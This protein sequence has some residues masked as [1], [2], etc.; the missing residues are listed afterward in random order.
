MK[1]LLRKRQAFFFRKLSEYSECPK[2]KST[3]DRVLA[4]YSHYSGQVN[5]FFLRSLCQYNIQRELFYPRYGFREKIMYAFGIVV[6]VLKSIYYRLCFEFESKQ[7]ASRKVMFTEH[8]HVFNKVLFEEISAARLVSEVKPLFSMK[9]MRY[10]LADIETVRTNQV[11]AEFLYYTYL[12]LSIYTF[13][14]L[15]YQ[16]KTIYSCMEQ[17]FTCSLVTGFLR[18]SGVVHVNLQHGIYFNKGPLVCFAAFDRFYV[19]QEELVKYF[20]SMFVVSE[21]SRFTTNYTKELRGIERDIRAKRSV[22]VFYSIYLTTSMANRL[23]LNSVLTMLGRSF[24]VFFKDHPLDPGGRELLAELAVTHPKVSF[25]RTAE[26]PKLV[27]S[28]ASVSISAL[29]AILR[30]SVESGALTI[31][32]GRDS[33]LKHMFKDRILSW[34]SDGQK[35]IRSAIESA[36]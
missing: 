10:M 8:K 11:T 18:T 23:A 34:E 21:F 35:K 17:N 30:D 27:L 29:S 31:S 26:E 5:D 33:M 3:I 16:P 4:F 13:L 15:K 9:T 25:V 36:L 28:K 6:V 22:V 12:W 19:E 7:S 2:S 24:R 32:L 14:V 1:V 20:K